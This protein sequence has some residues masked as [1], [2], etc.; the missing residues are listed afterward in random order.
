M[1]ELTGFMAWGTHS[2]SISLR[3]LPA[4]K[5]GNDIINLGLGELPDAIQPRSEGN[6]GVSGRP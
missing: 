4:P 5:I 6:M 3:V 2:A 1:E